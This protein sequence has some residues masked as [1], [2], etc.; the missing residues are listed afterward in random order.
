[1]LKSGGDGLRALKELPVGHDA[2]FALLADKPD[3]G[4]LRVVKDMPVDD[5]DQGPGRIRCRRGLF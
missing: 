4:P 3:M 2:F 1:M 5:V